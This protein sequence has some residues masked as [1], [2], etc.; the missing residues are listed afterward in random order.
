[1]KIKFYGMLGLLMTQIYSSEAQ[2][3]RNNVV[4]HFT[5]TKCGVC[6]WRNP[7]F[8]DN[9]VKQ[10]NTFHLAIHPSS[11]YS[12]CLLSQ[13]SKTDADARTKFYGVFGSTPRLV[14]NGTAIS[15]NENYDDTGIFTSYKNKT[16]PIA[17]YI[18]Q[19]KFKTD[20][21]LSRVVLKTVAAHAFADAV[22]FLG[23][24]EDT[25]F[26]TGSN[27]ESEHYD[28]FRKALTA[29]GGNTV[30]LASKVGDSV[31]L[32]FKSGVNG[33]WTLARMFTLGILQETSNKKLIQAGKS[34]L[35][36]AGSGTLGLNQNQIAP[37]IRLFPNPA[38]NW[39]QVQLD[40]NEPSEVIMFNAI[41]AEILTD[42]SA[43]G[44]HNIDLSEMAV[45]HYFIKATNTKGT[46]TQTFIKQ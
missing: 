36:N 41:G 18:T 28:V 2:V 22:L 8:Y 1:M 42:N 12:A 20:S 15:A 33:V 24:A 23:L 5:N 21:I 34:N 40:M 30:N 17:M 32:E 4:E 16:S 13:Q 31:V 6:A 44:L 39:L 7:G 14:I 37:A 27:G 25:I 45:G 46:T 19:K 11:P 10:N 38:G 43:N 26:Y 29:A 3:V 9:Y 35:M